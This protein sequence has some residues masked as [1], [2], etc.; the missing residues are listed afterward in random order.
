MSS[1]L[2]GLLVFVA[3]FSGVM[4]FDFW[5]KRR[6]SG[7]T[8][9]SNLLET[10]TRDWTREA[11]EGKLDP[12]VGRAEEIERVIHI[13]SRRRKNNPLLIGDPGVGKTAIIEV[14]AL[15]IVSGDIPSLL[16]NKRV[17]ALDLTGMISGTKF[18]G[19]LEERMKHLTEE[20]EALS[21]TVILFIDEMH[22]IQQS[23]GAEGAGP[24]APSAP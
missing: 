10:Y 14:L 23:A 19:E 24:P 22:I 15:R 13:L 5:R 2:V 3:V 4:L 7:G 18:R 16:K 21:R 9:T 12:V 17:L 6:G 11:K 20:I 1:Q 8:S